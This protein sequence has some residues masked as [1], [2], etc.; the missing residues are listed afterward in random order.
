MG[1]ITKFG[2][3]LDRNSESKVT[4]GELES[5]LKTVN[6]KID[7]VHVFL[8][9]LPLIQEHSNKAMQDVLKLRDELNA[10]KAY[11]KLSGKSPVPPTNPFDGSQA[12]KR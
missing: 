1:W 2:Q 8:N 10:V 3:W 9:Q 12:W 6:A 4:V 7:S 11:L 5:V